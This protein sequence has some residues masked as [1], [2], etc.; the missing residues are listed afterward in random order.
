V[1]ALYEEALVIGNELGDKKVCAMA[2]LGLAHTVPGA[3]AFFAHCEE[4]LRL[5]RQVDDPW[6]AAFALWM[7]GTATLHSGD[8][9]KAEQLLGESLALNTAVGERWNMAGA[10]VGLAELAMVRGDSAT[11]QVLLEQA[12]HLSRELDYHLGIGGQC[13]SL[14]HLALQAGHRAEA[15]AQ[16]RQAL[17]IY[18]E[19]GTVD[20]ANVLTGLASLALDEGAPAEAVRLASAAIHLGG[21]IP[22]GFSDSGHQFGVSAAPRILEEASQL[23]SE[24]EAAQARAEG[25]AM[26]LEQAIAYALE[27]P[28]SL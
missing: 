9:I 28:P 24:Q 8:L 10:N 4:G 3:A 5:Y 18:L 21:D 2:Y 25:Q 6:G 17:Q 26:T 15:R 7:L 23:L 12:L 13:A 20:S 22:W 1:R 27:D 14:G 11:A 16:Y 19:S